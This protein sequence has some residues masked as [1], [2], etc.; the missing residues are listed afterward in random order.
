MLRAP[1]GALLRAK[2]QAQAVRRRPARSLTVVPRAAGGGSGA[3]KKGLPRAPSARAAMPTPT[4]APS[5]PLSPTTTNT[6]T[7]DE[8]RQS[9]D[10]G[11]FARTVVFFNEPA[12]A[13]QGFLQRLFGGG[14]GN[15]SSNR[16]GNGSAATAPMAQPL[17]MT[18]LDRS[19]ETSSNNQQ[20]QLPGVTLVTGATGG[21]GRRVVAL[22][23]ARGCRVR[24]LVRDVPKA[25]KL[26]SGVSA[27]P[28]AVLELLPGD[29]TQ[30]ATLAASG[31]LGVRRVVSCAAT[32]VQ[33]KEGDDERR[34]KYSQGIKFFDPE[35]AS[36]API[37]VELK[38][39]EALLE[40]VASR[41]G[42][43]QGLPLLDAAAPDAALSLRDRWGALDDCVMGGVSE[44]SMV[45]SPAVAGAGSSSTRPAAVFRGVV[46]TANRGGFAS[47]RSRNFDAPGV[48]VSAY[49]G[50]EMV[51][52]GDGQ[53]YKAILRSDAGW[54]GIGY[55]CSFVAAK[56]GGNN[57]DGWTTV[58]LPF[59]AFF[60]VFRA[61]RLADQPAFDPATQPI[62]SMQLMLSK[63]EYDG[64]L[65]P[66]F[67]PGAFELPVASIKAYVGAAAQ[68]AGSTAAPAPRFVH[69]SSAGVTRPKRPGIDVEQEPPAVKLN[70]ALGGLLDYKLAGEQALRESG[71]PFAV[72]RPCALTEEP[73]G[74]PVEAGQGDVLKGKIGRDDVAEL[75]VEL[76]LGSPGLPR[77]ATF[78]IK[79]RVPFSEPWTP[80]KSA[81][82]LTGEGVAQATQA[83]DWAKLLSA[84]ELK[85]GVTGRTVDGVYTG[86]AAEPGWADRWSA[87][88]GEK[89]VV[90]PAEVARA[91]E[92]VRA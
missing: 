69:V 44:S 81:E 39:M 71:V 12:R 48:D 1:G 32:V 26:L 54:D 89:V 30:P 33:P 68:A 34:S 55:C 3:S 29:L 58:R 14:D 2:A 62:A 70:D 13:V 83:R 77:D 38:G 45:Y 59:S 8:A 40:R 63:F 66:Q 87:Q 56:A 86:A 21:V 64:E 92:A 37:D 41:V 53:R 49:D 35:I 47:V 9:W 46:S 19:S 52:R 60:P 61:R 36:D 90:G 25:Q 42:S 57:D 18:L 31:F 28:G 11:R 73:R 88:K 17:V 75:C 76:L 50:I 82:A 91:A 27:A 15:S 72:V 4:D 85:A 80:E 78:E 43:F 24:C 23:L 5:P 22:L 79:S 7:T 67:S 6:T 74:M 10:F 65:N 84:A 16:S 20:Q 51:V